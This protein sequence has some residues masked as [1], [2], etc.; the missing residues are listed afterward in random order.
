MADAIEQGKVPGTFKAFVTKFPALGKAHEEVA[1]ACVSAGPMDAKM[2]ELVKIGI[3]L[4]A[5]LESALK[6]HVRRA[7]EKGATEAEVEQAII[8]GMNTVGFPRTVA[9][10]SWAREQFA[11]DRGEAG[12]GHRQTQTDTDRGTT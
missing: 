4:G 11:R 6:S 12:I 10:W 1:R 8:L 5:G 7:M 3:S 2:C 9:G